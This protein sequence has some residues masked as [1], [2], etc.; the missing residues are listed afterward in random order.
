M[1]HC[2]MAQQ[3]LVR[4]TLTRVV[5]WLFM[6]LM[7]P[8]IQG[9]AFAAGDHGSPAAGAQAAVT[10]PR[11]TAESELFELVGVLKGTTLTLWLDRWSDNTAVPDA[12]IELE[13]A[14]EKVVARPAAQGSTYEATLSKPL[15]A[16]QHPVVATV[17]AGKDTDL[18]NGEFDIHDAASPQTHA[19]AHGI[20]AALASHGLL[21][22]MA[23][24]VALLLF[25]L[26]TW[27]L[28]SRGRRAPAREPDLPFV[29]QT[30]SKA[31]S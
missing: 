28:V 7:M 25:G 17:Q 1:T 2:R 6:V 15:G 30:H 23:S 21:W 20:R 18:L 29:T 11:F 4:R 16:G 10:S 22:G 19:D 27:R 8:A 13:I 26:A 14:G 31:R 12:R 9:V 5:R 3:K 24:L